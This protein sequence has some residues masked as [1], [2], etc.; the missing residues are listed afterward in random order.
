MV[1]RGIIQ[2][3]I[4][5]CSLKNGDVF[6]VQKEQ[7]SYV[8]IYEKNLF[9][10]DSK[11]SSNIL[12]YFVTSYFPVAMDLKKLGNKFLQ[13]SWKYCHQAATILRDF[14]PCVLVFCHQ[15]GLE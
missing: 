15:L 2:F 10:Q 8:S 14:E 7:Y 5:C 9:G 3:E 11:D 1:S 6:M 13:S 12:S 4:C